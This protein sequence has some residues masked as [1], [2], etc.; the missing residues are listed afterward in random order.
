MCEVPEMPVIYGSTYNAALALYFAPR[1]TSPGGEPFSVRTDVIWSRASQ[2]GMGGCSGG[3]PEAFGSARLTAEL[4]GGYVY[5][6]TDTVGGTEWESSFNAF[7]DKIV[8]EVGN[9]ACK[10]PET[11]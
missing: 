7:L 11:P 2:L 9:Y 10:I 8:D 5:P 6:E 3:G 4:G 1:L